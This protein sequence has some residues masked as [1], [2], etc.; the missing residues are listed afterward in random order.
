MT[1]LRALNDAFEELERRADAATA[2][3]PLGLPPRT[4]PAAS[5]SR[6]RLVPITL[7]A[8]VV[9]GVATGAVLL[10]PT[11]DPGSQTG[12]LAASSTPPPVTTTSTPPP[13]PAHESPEVLAE[14]FRAV[15]GDLGTFVVT[16]TGPGASVMTLPAGPLTGAPTTL[17]PEPTKQVGSSIVGTLTATGVTGGFDLLMY[18][19]RAGDKAQCALPDEPSCTVRDLPD[20]ST[21]ATGQ[22]GLE[23]SGVTNE[24]KLIRPDGLVFGMHVSNRQSPKGSGPVLAG[25][26]PLT[27]EQLVAIA[28]SDRW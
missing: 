4:R 5:W 21:L 25:H 13:P 1:D 8:A 18:P 15:L 2:R 23:G 16:E 19:G 10:V 14:R 9:A 24:V 17:D 20:G 11:N 12:L 27:V 28:T 7:A 3:M 6:T 22:F 26:P